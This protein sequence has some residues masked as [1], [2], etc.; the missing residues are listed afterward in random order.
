M[1]HG[2]WVLALACVGTAGW[3]D[4]RSRRIPNWLTL[5][6]LL[7]GFGFNTVAGGWRG[8]GAA[9]LGAILMLGLLLPFVL[10]R[11]M[12]A[13]DWKLMG[14]LGSILGPIQI[15]LVFLGTIFI[16]GI[17]AVVQVVRVKRVRATF[18][19]MWELV[20]GF[21]V[22]GLGPHPVIRLDNPQQLTLPYGVAVAAATVLCYGAG[23][24]LSRF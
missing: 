2:R 19:N 1:E 11:A 12:G 21:F 7:L 13:G 15:L 8:A 23:L 10:L 9:F 24:A 18:A 3:L 16:T 6:A 22:Y 14:A 4:W 5:S 20:R 17:M